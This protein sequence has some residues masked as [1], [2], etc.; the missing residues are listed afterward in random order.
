MCAKVVY[1]RLLTYDNRV[2]LLPRGGNKLSIQNIST[3]YFT[4][5]LNTI[6][7]VLNTIL[8]IISTEYYT[9]STEYYTEY[10]YY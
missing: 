6:L 7:K 4:L 10:Y 2:T 8:N 5:V 3:E 1:L 9:A